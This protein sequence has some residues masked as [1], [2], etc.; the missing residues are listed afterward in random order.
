[1]ST[2]EPTREELLERVR[3]LEGRLRRAERY[4]GA[5]VDLVT[6]LRNWS[7]ELDFFLKRAYLNVL[8]LQ[9]TEPMPARPSPTSLKNP[10]TNPR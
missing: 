5:Y 3:R 8:T 6:R 9:G 1:M 4:E 10:D 2:N 7:L